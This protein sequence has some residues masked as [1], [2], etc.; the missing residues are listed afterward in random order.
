MGNGVYGLVSIFKVHIYT[1]IISYP[2]RKHKFYDFLETFERRI[3]L[4]SRTAAGFSLPAYRTG[5]LHP[6]T[7]IVCVCRGLCGNTVC[8]CSTIHSSVYFIKWQVHILMQTWPWYKMPFS[9]NPFLPLHNIQRRF[10]F[11]GTQT[12][13]FTGKH[14]R[15]GRS[16]TSQGAGV[17]HIAVMSRKLL[18]PQSASDRFRILLC[19]LEMNSWL[20]SGG[21]A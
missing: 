11:L 5:T 13:Y 10:D 1:I 21:R 8:F 3:S 17:H 15:F 9:P 19:V 2:R 20:F 18:S 4:I 7:E 6:S 12:R 16:F 14:I